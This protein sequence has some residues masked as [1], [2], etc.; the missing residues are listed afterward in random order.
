[1]RRGCTGPDMEPMS[2]LHSFEGCIAVSDP[3]AEAAIGHNFGDCTSEAVDIGQHTAQTRRRWLAESLGCCSGM[4]LVTAAPVRQC[5]ADCTWP[6]L[7]IAVAAAEAAAAPVGPS[8]LHSGLGGV[9]CI[10]LGSDWP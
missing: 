3:G 9:G 1:M 4:R 2:L 10:F 7:D 5:G 8:N 6:G